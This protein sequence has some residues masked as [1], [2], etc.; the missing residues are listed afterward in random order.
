MLSLCSC[1]QELFCSVLGTI[2]FIEEE[3]GWF[4]VACRKCSKKVVS[5]QEYVVLDD[6]GED[7]H[8]GDDVMWCKK[9]K[10]RATAVV[11]K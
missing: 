7:V 6:I 8:E 2:K 5:R 9:C 1:F 3:Y 4:Y 10:I 11:P